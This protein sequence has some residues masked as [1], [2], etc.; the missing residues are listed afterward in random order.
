MVGVA[1][2]RFHSNRRKLYPEFDE[3]LKISMVA[4]TE[5]FFQEI[6]DLSVLT[7]IDRFCMV[8][9]DWQLTTESMVFK[10]R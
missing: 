7:S 4:E 1:G 6:L 2:Y 10:V 8:N 3:L 9:R 5:A